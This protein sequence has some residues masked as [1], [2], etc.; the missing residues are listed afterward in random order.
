MTRVTLKRGE[1]MAR[2]TPA[3][4]DR[5]TKI[6]KEHMDIVGFITTGSTTPSQ[7]LVQK[8]GLPSALT[9]LVT[10]AY[11]YGKLSI[12]KGKNLAAMGV[13]E[14]KRLLQDITLT[15][16]Q[17][18][19]VDQV[20]IKSQQ[21][22]NTLTQKI[23][24]GVTTAALN[25]DLKMW[26]A[27]QKVVSSA[28]HHDTPRY[29]VIQQLREQSGDWKRDWHRVAQT[30][31]WDAKLQG[32]A[33]SIIQGNSPM[34]DDKGDTLVYKRPAP[35]ACAKCKQLYLESD[36]VTPKVFKMS[37]LLSNGTNYGKKQSDWVPTLGVIHPNCCCTLGIMPKGTKF[38]GNGNLVPDKK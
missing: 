21:A 11:Q 28:L 18:Y 2:I 37:D 9:N 25:S 30:E 14:V 8:L 29:Q 13:N 4:I 17:Q 24:A 1:N 7:R 15:K 12:L 10:T 35:D 16:A 38:D 27:V 3:Q 31:M 5:I 34:S 22:I 26:S 23:I 20:K 36:G 6:I 33:E 32:E 19:S